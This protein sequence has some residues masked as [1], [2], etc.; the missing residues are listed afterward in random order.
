MR[1]R[2]SSITGVLPSVHGFEDLCRINKSSTFQTAPPGPYPGTVEIASSTNLTKS[3]SR[4]DLLFCQ[5]ACG[6][7]SEKNHL[8]SDA[9]TSK[10]RIEP[11]LAN[12][13]PD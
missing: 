3:P 9:R 2:P 11:R 1:H 7:G 8:A 4:N 6:I 12:S 10:R 5:I 13:H